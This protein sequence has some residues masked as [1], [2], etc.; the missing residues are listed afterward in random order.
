MSK[1]TGGSK[2]IMNKVLKLF[3]IP[4][5]RTLI[6]NLYLILIS[7][8]EYWCFQKSC[9]TDWYEPGT[10][11][12]LYNICIH[13]AVNYVLLL[14][15][16]REYIVG[17]ITV[18]VTFA[19]AEANYYTAL[20]HGMPLTFS[21]LRNFKTAMNVVGSY[22]IPFS[23]RPVRV[24]LISAAAMLITLIVFHFDKKNKDVKRI[25]TVRLLILIPA[26]AWFVAG[27]WG[28]NPIKPKDAKDWQWKWLYG[29]FGY[30]NCLVDDLKN[31]TNL[32]VKPEGYSSENV[33]KFC[34]EYMSANE[35]A[36]GGDDPDIILIL[37]ESFYD[38]SLVYDIKTDVDYLEKIHS[39]EDV[40][41]GYAVS[42]NL[43]GGTNASEYELL[44][45]NSLALMKNGI[46]PFNVL[47]MRGRSSIVSV[48]NDRGYSTFGTHPAPG[49][50]YNRINGYPDLGFGTVRFIDDYE[51]VEY[52]YDRE[53]VTD[54]SMFDNA[55][56]WY[57]Q[58]GDAPRFMYLLTIQN[59]ADYASNGP[60][61][62]LVHVT[63]GDFEDKDKLN[64]YLS[65]VSLSDE[66]F[67]DLTRY[68]K[69]CGR[70]VIVCM[71]GDHCPNFV[72]EDTLPDSLS[73]DEAN[74]L[75]REVPLLIWANY[76][77]AADD[78]DLGEMSMMYVV[79]T[80][81]DMVGVRQSYYYSF[82]GDMKKE[83]PFISSDGRCFDKDKTPISLADNKELSGM[84][85]E[86]YDVEYSNVTAKDRV[87]AFFE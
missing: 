9:D 18:P 59:H 14:I 76:D 23:G 26:A 69:D 40:Y 44:T 15:T 80:L 77:L 66:A 58:M 8:L 29:I 33:E 56:S 27:M 61:H 32:I 36:G 13:V 64:E 34:S 62:D 65:C 5:V 1:E 22:G 39:M 68:F 37:N 75:M 21:E 79:P 2:E 11:V 54:K 16:A 47:D 3:A 4:W 49:Y 35:P 78:K 24:A 84:L 50:N 17:F 12:I 53:L 82:I 73:V 19:W 45:S 81:L 31:R 57:E 74:L 25:G 72:T 85:E 38:P 60:E 10:V 51:N 6:L 42:P 28:P 71:L 46:T 63:G 20:F 41:S 52:Y 48:L 30:T 55:V 7:A 67:Y 86:Y 70:K 43:R 83:A 87:D